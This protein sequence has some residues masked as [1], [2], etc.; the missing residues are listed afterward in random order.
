MNEILDRYIPYNNHAASYSWKRM[1]Q[2]LDMKKTLSENGIHDETEECIAL[3][4]DPDEYIPVLHLYF[5]DDLT[6]M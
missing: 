5:N 6:I 1:G 4:I 3:G 2:V